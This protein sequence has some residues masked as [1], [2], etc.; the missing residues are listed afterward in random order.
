MFGSVFLKR[1]WPAL[2]A[3]VCSGWLV[4]STAWAQPDPRL[5]GLQRLH[6]R[7]AD[8]GQVL[9]AKD[10]KQAADRLAEWRLKSEQLAPDDRAR[11]R[12]V[13]LYVAL[14][15]GDA[16]TAL[17]RARALL[18]DGTADRV[19][20]EA[21][22]LAACAAGDAQLGTQALRKL[23]RFVHGDE[24][25]RLSQRRRWLR[26][27]GKKAP[28]VVIRTE[29]M[30]EFSTTQRGDRVLLIDFWNVRVPPD[31]Q[32]IKAL[33]ELYQQYRRTR[34]VDFVGVNADAEARVDEAKQFA[35]NNR[36]AWKQRY[37][38]EARHAPL[39]DQAFQAGNPP[40][41][42]FIDTLGYVRAVGAASEPGLQYALRAAVAEAAGD[43]EIVLPRTREGRQPTR[44]SAQ[45]R[46]EP[47][48]PQADE[49]AGEPPS[50]PEALRKLRLARTYLR[51][52]KRSD[53]KRL[54]EE[55][56]RDYPGTREAQEAQEYLDS[57]WNP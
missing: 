15:E 53:A 47:K 14:A 22:Y 18:S 28:E 26:R 52:G 39:T 36:Y 38:Y 7:I 54:F 42:V 23:S 6:D 56:V 13:E 46:P 33:R 29:D 35:E 31:D 10:A 51:T 43:H 25:R 44:P 50:N 20:F 27:V 3:I 49:P 16:R 48:A 40:W 9:T 17:E 34:H 32:D 30:T 8:A 37:E 45:I 11:L 57:I 4:R 1:R 21:A 12:R 19:T 24:R 5:S 2:V 55:I 41:S